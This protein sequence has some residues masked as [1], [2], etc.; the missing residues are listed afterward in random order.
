M[1][2][3]LFYVDQPAIPRVSCI[4]LVR[5]KGKVLDSVVEFVAISMVNN[6]AVRDGS[7]ICHGN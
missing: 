7:K 3:V 6:K 2:G 4:F 1:S 5:R